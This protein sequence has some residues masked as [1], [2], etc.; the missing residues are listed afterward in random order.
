[1]QPLMLS[2][3]SKPTRGKHDSPRLAGDHS[4]FISAGALSVKPAKS[5][6]DKSFVYTPSHKTDVKETFARARAL[7]NCDK[8]E[9]SEWWD[10]SKR[11]CRRVA[12]Q[13]YGEQ[14]VR[15]EPR[16]EHDQ[17]TQGRKLKEGK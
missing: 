6:L 11:G 10:C 16:P 15:F 7:Q 17:D 9:C 5:I 8:S 3:P 14:I 2:A 4:H 1:M 12:M 13:R